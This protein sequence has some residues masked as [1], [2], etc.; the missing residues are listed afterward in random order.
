MEVCAFYDPTNFTY[1]AGAHIAEVEIDRDTGEVTLLNFTAA[2][3][4]GRIINP[5]IVEGQVHG[6]LVQ[7]IGQALHEDAIYDTESGQLR[8]GTLMD[9]CLPRA[10]NVPVFYFF[11]EHGLFERH[12]N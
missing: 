10:E 3:D 11:C 8:T 7:G 2:D 9:Y 12:K 5:M 4:F 1:P 6:G